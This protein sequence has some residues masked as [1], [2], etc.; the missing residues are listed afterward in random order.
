MNFRHGST[1][2]VPNCDE[3]LTDR[4]H[5]NLRSCA[6]T[7]KSTKSVYRTIRLKFSFFDDFVILSFYN[8]FAIIRILISVLTTI[9]R[10]CSSFIVSGFSIVGPAVILSA[11]AR[12]YHH[13][14][15]FWYWHAPSL[16]SLSTHVQILLL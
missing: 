12:A 13:H 9:I 15:L 10:V 6:I 2:F 5:F 4:I 1:I 16:E 7:S 8:L 14:H 11:V 3:F